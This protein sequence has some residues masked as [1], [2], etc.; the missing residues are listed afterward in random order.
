MTKLWYTENFENFHNEM[1]KFTQNMLINLK[2]ATTKQTDFISANTGM[3]SKTFTEAQFYV[4]EVHLSV[5]VSLNRALDE[6]MRVLLKLNDNFQDTVDAGSQVKLE[7]D[8]I[9]SLSKDISTK[10]E[11]V[12]QAHSELQKK[13]RYM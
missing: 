8:K 9:T 2:E 3:K 6:Y 12:Y 10:V 4:G 1:K 11:D 7:T 5:I 13:N